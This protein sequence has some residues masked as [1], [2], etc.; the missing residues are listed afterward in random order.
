[1]SPQ[2][3]YVLVGIALGIAALMRGLWRVTGAAHA[4]L[5]AIKDNTRATGAL[6][7][8]FAE[9][10]RHTHR[11]LDEHAERIARLE[12]RRRHGEMQPVPHP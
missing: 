5:S 4:L 8:D 12:G 9:L 6:S 7:D 10:R 11:R 2:S 3:I 1:M